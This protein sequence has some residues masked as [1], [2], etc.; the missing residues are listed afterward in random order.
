MTDVVP[1][2]L[3][4]ESSQ[5]MQ[6]LRSA[7]G[8]YDE[9][10]MTKAEAAALIP[11]V[12]GYIRQNPAS[13]SQYAILQADEPASRDFVRQVIDGIWSNHKTES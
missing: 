10:P 4:E 3:N 8:N 9:G 12:P 2:H 5:L 6:D 11:L 1:L 13:V 7:L